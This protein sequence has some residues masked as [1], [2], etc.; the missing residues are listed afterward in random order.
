M[1]DTRSQRK[2]IVLGGKLMT[3]DPASIA[4]NF[5]TLKNYRYTDTHIRGHPRDE[6]ARRD[7]GEHR[8]RMGRFRRVG[9]LRLMGDRGRILQRQKLPSL[10]QVTASRDASAD[11]AVQQPFGWCIVWHIRF[12]GGGS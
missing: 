1:P 12:N 9:E 2:D 8:G 4:E 7:D 6:R 11:T 10:P 3:G 5:Q